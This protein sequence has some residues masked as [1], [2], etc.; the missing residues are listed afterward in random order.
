MAIKTKRSSDEQ[1]ESPPQKKVKFNTKISTST[2]KKD[3]F[4]KSGDAKTKKFGAG[5]SKFQKDK[6]FTNKPTT[7]EKKDWNKL[8]KDKKELRLKRKQTKDLF[9]ITAQGKKIYEKLKCKETP[10]RSTLAKELHALLKGEQNYQ[11]LVLAHDTARVVQCLLKLAP[12]EIKR[13]ISE[14]LIPIIVQ[15]STS[16]YAHFCVSRMVKY[17]TPDI[18]QKIIEGMYGNVVKM[19]NHQ[20]SSAILDNIYISWASSQQ[21]SS[22]RQELYGDLYKGSKD[23]SVKCIADTY[24][25]SP[26]LKVAILNSVKSNLNHVVNKKLLDNSLIHAVLL[27]YLNECNDEDR[28]E[29]ITAVSPFIPSLASTKEGVRSSMICFWNSIVKD[30][31]A[32]VKSL[33][34]H[35]IKLC[36]HEHG[37]VL[38]LAIIN[39]MDDTKALKKAIFDNLFAQIEYVA[40]NEWGK[41]IIQWFVTPGDTTLFHPKI[42][43]FLEEGL[44]FSKKDKNVRRTE[45]FEAVEKPL[46]EAIANNPT[47]WLRGGHTALATAAILKN[48]KGD[49]LKSAY[50]GLADVVCDPEWK[51][52]EKEIEQHLEEEKED[53]PQKDDKK[54]KKKK[55]IVNPLVEATPTV[56]SDPT[57]YGV[58]HAGLHIV[59]KKILK[60]DKEKKERNEPTFGAA[61]AQK[62]TPQTM[63]LWF[64]LNRASFLFLNAFENGTE[65]T[66]ALLKENAASCKKLLKKQKHQ[67]AKIILKK[68][69]L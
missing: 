40:S 6:H 48:S 25:D 42:T 45:L 13:E 16:K 39:S 64:T 35:L 41:K 32:I 62:M 56:Q 43:E 29:M 61:I 50:D 60:S 12:A 26:H 31:R 67:A 8:K 65:E 37:H 66:C 55:I 51:V 28:A 24:K 20:H 7:S 57:T 10:D 5:N 15:M 30:R 33:K 4:A 17:G 63:E 19:I 59:L 46:C 3:G 21:K 52:T 22:L 23:D 53:V 9:E 18:K 38:I 44:K 2:Q 47:F 11:K 58:E 54:I 27:D 1:P 49:C 34:E 68:L 14:N 36:V 69:E